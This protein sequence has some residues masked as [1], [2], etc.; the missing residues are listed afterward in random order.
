[1]PSDRVEEALAAAGV[2]GGERAERLGLEEFAAIA[3]V[4]NVP[5]R[6]GSGR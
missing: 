3:R 1:V 5:S 4:L 6:R 2:A